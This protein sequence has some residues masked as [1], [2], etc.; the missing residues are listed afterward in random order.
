MALNY[1]PWIK[2]AQERLAAIEQQKKILDA[3]ASALR[4]SIEN[5]KNLPTMP[6]TSELSLTAYPPRVNRFA[7]ADLGLT[8]AIRAALIA[9]KGSFMAPTEIRDAIVNR[10][11]NFGD[12]P[13]PM[14][15]VH[16]VLHRLV[17]QDQAETMEKDGKPVYRCKL[18]SYRESVNKLVPPARLGFKERK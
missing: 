5:F 1:E 11:F 4:Q 16:Q 12:R 17:D 15:N 13:N 18:G 14:A 6:P 7:D 2:A 8:G 10:G 3:E 9:N